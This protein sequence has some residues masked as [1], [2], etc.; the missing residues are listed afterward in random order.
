MPSPWTLAWP[1]RARA[2]RAHYFGLALERSQALWVG[3]VLEANGCRLFFSGDT[4]YGLH[5]AE[6]A[7][8]FQGFRAL[9]TWTCRRISVPHLPHEVH[10]SP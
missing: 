5:F 7:K 6:I 3:F 2:S 1:G 8:R 4:G 10:E 9:A